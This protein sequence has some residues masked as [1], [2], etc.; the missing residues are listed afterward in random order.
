[1]LA[2]SIALLGEYHSESTYA[3]S[4]FSQTAICGRLKQLQKTAVP[5][6]SPP[7]SGA[8]GDVHDRQTDCK[9][10]RSRHRTFG[11]RRQQEDYGTTGSKGS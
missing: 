1:M 10:M 8:L 5:A 2:A 7:N 9:P 11:V 3:A 6:I 4:A